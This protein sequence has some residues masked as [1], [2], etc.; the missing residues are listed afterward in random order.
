MFTPPIVNR[1]GI[2]GNGRVARALALGLREH[3]AA[4]P[5]VWGRDP[6]K[7]TQAADGDWD[8]SVDIAALMA[9]CDVVA[10]AVSDDAI[11]PIVASIAG[12]GA[13]PHSPFV[14]H[15]SG[16]SGVGVLEPIERIGARTAAIHPAM[17]FT[18]DAPIEVRRMRATRFAITGSS[19]EATQHAH[20]LVDAL[21]GVAVEI[22]EAHR[23]LYHAGLCHAAN[24]LVTLLTGAAQALGAAGVEHP[25]ALLAPL[26]RAALENGLDRGMDALS[27]PLLRGDAT[28]IQQH[29][30][31]MTR[32]VPSLLPA[33]RAMADATLDELDRRAGTATRGEVREALMPEQR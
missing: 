17:T 32:D 10:I 30:R 16:A 5:L 24:H 6:G 8:V 2:I 9:A 33:Y 21:G 26:V 31:A 23:T 22:A 7:V 15:V 14:F 20:A 4:R 27:G 11:V 28:T 25:M 3:C 29:V 19:G 13:L 1:L 18:G 12:I